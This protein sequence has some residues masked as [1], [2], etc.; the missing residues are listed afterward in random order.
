MKVRSAPDA[1]RH[2]DGQPGRLRRPAPGA[3]H[4]LERP[5][6][7]VGKPSL[8]EMPSVSYGCALGSSVG[9]FSAVAVSTMLVRL[10]PAL[11]PPARRPCASGG[12]QPPALDGDRPLRGGHWSALR[13]QRSGTAVCLRAGRDDLVAGECPRQARVPCKVRRTWKPV[14]GVNIWYRIMPTRQATSRPEHAPS[15]ARVAEA[16]G[17]SGCQTASAE[18]GPGKPSRSR[19][20]V[21]VPLGR[22][23]S[24]HRRA[25]EDVRQG[26][27]GVPLWDF[28]DPAP[29]C[30][31]RRGTLRT[32]S[33]SQSVVRAS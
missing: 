18:D 24:R 5:R 30:Y 22:G 19:N 1:L 7:P 12:H 15:R 11:T 28:P 6:W 13:C 9:Y 3:L 25:R 17:P 27:L 16:D 23:R 32:R 4:G 20:T 10:G 33:F 29:G 2:R 26:L 21:Y 8:C 31:V 14:F